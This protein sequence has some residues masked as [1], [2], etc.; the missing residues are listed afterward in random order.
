MPSRLSS[1]NAP[2]RGKGWSRV[3][4]GVDFSRNGDAALK[5]A[6]ALPLAQG[7]AVSIVHVLP[8]NL[9][10]S[11]PANVEEQAKRSVEKLQLRAQKMAERAKRPDLLVR[12]E[13]VRG[14]PWE[15]LAKLC[16]ADSVDLV[17]LGRHGTSTMREQ[18][19]GSTAERLVRA[20]NVPVLIVQE[21]SAR[22]YKRPLF[23]LDFAQES[24]AVLDVGLRMVPQVRQKVTLVHAYEHG[25]D[26]VLRQVNASAAKIREYRQQAMRDAKVRADQFLALWQNSGFEF[27]IQLEGED[28]RISIPRAAEEHEADLLVVGTHGRTGAA[29]FFLGSVAEAVLRNASCDV[30]VVRVEQPV[31]RR[32]VPAPA[33]GEAE[34]RT[35]PDMSY[36]V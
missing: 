24:H 21:R 13:L 20:V 6:F 30:L 7:A 15:Q 17:I 19:L 10:G 34:G 8:R 16:Q 27:D 33:R 31:R 12:A 29:R 3:L 2:P 23:A 14:T 32:Q 5:R 9:P 1:R 35:A 36:L 25:Y 22:A 26:L 4:V 11:F 18:L 28:A